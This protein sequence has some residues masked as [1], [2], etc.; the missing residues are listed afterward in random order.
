MNYFK[1]T[2]ENDNV[3][4]MYFFRFMKNSLK[5]VE[6]DWLNFFFEKKIDK[7]LIDRWMFDLLQ[8]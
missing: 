4:D 5:E 1:T 2:Y 8:K 6:I 3:N 7:F